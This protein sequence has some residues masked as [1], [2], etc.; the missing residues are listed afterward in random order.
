MQQ[1]P[2]QLVRLG[3]AVL[4]HA[5]KGRPA[6]IAQAHQLGGFVKRLARS[7]V[8]RLAQQGVMPHAIDLHQLGVPARYQQRHKRK[9][10]RVGTQKRRQQMPL[11]MVHAQHRF[12]Q[13]G[14]QCAGHARAHQQSARK[15]R[16][17]RVGDHVHLTQSAASVAKHL[18]RQR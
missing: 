10:G 1:R 12:A 14:T 4:G 8:N 2:W 11:Q 13:S 9:L 7:I 5:G 16:P 3:V 17:A 6:G 18:S 15:A